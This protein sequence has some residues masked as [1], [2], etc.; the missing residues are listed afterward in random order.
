V[1]VRI[2]LNSRAIKPD[3]LFANEDM[4]KG[5]MPMANQRDSP[6][7]PLFQL[8]SQGN[9]FE[10]ALIQGDPRST[11]GRASA[12]QLVAGLGSEELMHTARTERYR[13]VPFEIED[14]NAIP[15]TVLRSVRLSIPLAMIRL[16]TNRY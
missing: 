3:R 9:W 7:K 13:F 1:G 4:R 15:Q 6:F 2:G 5:V 11:T 12:L 10:E 8:S 14:V 16:E